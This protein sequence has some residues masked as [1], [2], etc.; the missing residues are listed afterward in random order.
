MGPEADLQIKIAPA[1]SMSRESFTY[2]LI[3]TLQTSGQLPMYKLVPVTIADE[4]QMDILNSGAIQ[5]ALALKIVSLDEGG[6]FNPKD[7]IT[8]TDGTAMVSR[9]QEI[10][11]DKGTK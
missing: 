1:A 6:N 7:P 5:T 10:L 8:R 4:D 11:K 9:V 2:L 3:N